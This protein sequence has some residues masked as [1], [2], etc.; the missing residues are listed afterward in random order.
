MTLRMPFLWVDHRP[1]IEFYVREGL[2]ERA[3]SDAQLARALDLMKTRVGV[4][5]QTIFYAKHPNLIF[6]SKAKRRFVDNPRAAGDTR[7]R[8]DAPPE[9]AARR[10]AMP[11]L[12]R[13]LHWFTLFS[14]A[15]FLVKTFFNPWEAI[16]GS[17][18]NAPAW[19]LIAH[20]LQTTHPPPG[21]W[22]LQVIHPD[23]GALDALE[24]Q[25]ERALRGDGLRA[26]INRALGSQPNHFENLKELIPRVRRFEY[27]PM[28]EGIEARNENLILFLNHAARLEA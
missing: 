3:P 24:R 20:T 9:L 10:A 17:G 5:G 28:P 21:I 13:F 23:R 6:P 1:R 26:R 22:D 15:R 11:A 19:C 12:D 18:L 4:L 25:V 27:P 7:P 8:V 14:P 16:P 2:V